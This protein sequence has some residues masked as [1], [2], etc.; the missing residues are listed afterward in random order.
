[1]THFYDFNTL[2]EETLAAMSMNEGFEQRRSKLCYFR[3]KSNDIYCGNFT[4]LPLIDK[5]QEQ[6]C[7]RGRPKEDVD[8]PATILED[9]LNVTPGEFCKTDK[10]SIGNN[11][12]LEVNA[13]YKG[14]LSELEDIFR[15][16][17]P[18]PQQQQ[19]CLELKRFASLCKIAFIIYFSLYCNIFYALSQLKNKLFTYQRSSSFG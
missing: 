1:M 6:L 18:Q 14:E 7:E 12:G 17:L 16:Y 13:T 10:Y 3:P 8:F 11:Y 4:K 9:N 15:R 5:L 2:E 19:Q